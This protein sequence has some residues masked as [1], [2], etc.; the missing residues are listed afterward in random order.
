MK[1]IILSLTLILTMLLFAFL[2][3]YGEERSMRA[4]YNAR[5]SHSG[6]GNFSYLNH[7][8]NMNESTLTH[9]GV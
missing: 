2:K 8:K 6:S 3:G 4:E 7:D 1:K 5:A 9:N